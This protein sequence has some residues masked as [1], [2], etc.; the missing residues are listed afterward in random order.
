M[1]I[2]QYLPFV[3]SVSFGCILADN[4]T[5]PTKGYWVEIGLLV[6][7]IEGL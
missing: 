3:G 2:M 1:F 4:C 6:N 7:T 5:F